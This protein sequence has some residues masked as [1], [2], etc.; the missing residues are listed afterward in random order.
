M[1]L[2]GRTKTREGVDN[3][4][5]NMQYEQASRSMGKPPQHSE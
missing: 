1:Q 2:D 3:R 5:K 4:S